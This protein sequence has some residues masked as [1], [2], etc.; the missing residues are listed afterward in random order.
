ML[1]SFFKNQKPKQFEF[2]ARYYDAGKEEFEERVRRALN[3]QDSSRTE[4]RIRQHFRD[5]K[6][7]RTA[8]GKQA[9]LRVVI[10]AL[11]LLLIAWYIFS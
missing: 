5:R 11:A 6:K 8:S 9:N 10:I 7:S 3:N 4:F 2:R 1:F